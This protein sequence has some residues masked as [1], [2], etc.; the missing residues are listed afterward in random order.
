MMEPEGLR[1]YRMLLFASALLFLAQPAAYGASASYF[2]GTC[3]GTATAGCP[4]LGE[5]QC[6]A[7]IAPNCVPVYDLSGNFAGCSG[8]FVGNCS[9]YGA[10]QT[11]CQALGCT[12]NPTPCAGQQCAA[13]SDCCVRQPYCTDPGIGI[14][15]CAEDWECEAEQANSTCDLATGF[16]VFHNVCGACIAQGSGSCSPEGAQGNCCAGLTCSSG[17]CRLNQAPAQPAAPIISASS[18]PLAPGGGVECT[19]NCPPA[20]IP[21]DPETGAPAA[22]QYLWHVN[23]VPR[24]LWGATPGTFSCI[25]CIPLDAVTLHSRACS[26]NSR[27]SPE[28]VSNQVAV[29]GTGAAGEMF[30]ATG[31]FNGILQLCALAGLGMIAIVAIAYMAGESLSNARVLTWAKAEALQVFAS[32]VVVAVIF[33]V[34]AV[35]CDVRIDEVGALTGASIPEIYSGANA[36]QNLNFFNGSMVYLENLAGAGLSNIAS[37]RY[38]LGA[39]EIRTSFNRYVCGDDTCLLSLSST[40]EGVFAGETFDLAITN[41]LLGLATVSYLSATFMYFTLLYIINGLFIQFLPIAIVMRSVPFMRQFGGALIAIFVSLYLM[42][43]AMLVADSF[44]VRGFTYFSG[45]ASI[46]DRTDGGGGCGGMDVFGGAVSC[47]QGRSESDL[48]RTRPLPSEGSIRDL[49]P[50]GAPL[51]APIKFNTLIFLSSVFLPAV[52]F[53]VIAALARDLSRFLGEEADI[54]RLGQMV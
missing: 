24:G 25:G 51:D 46:I 48:D 30:C 5:M 3:S 20:A 9:D 29:Q 12:W 34:M 52:N 50:A 26:V 4:G 54:S 42:Y 35:M 41:N 11:M 6:S 1:A 27:C 37:L 28:A 8:T 13:D 10:N 23:G 17:V 40:N 18:P 22:M 38:N 33:W 45:G 39:Y 53:I 2:L 44:V 19:Q 14:W 31:Q 36:A 15:G 32:L 7:S 43:P 16:C 47:T 21:A 49:L